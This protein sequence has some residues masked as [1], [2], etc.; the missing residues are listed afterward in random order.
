MVFKQSSLLCI[1]V[2]TKQS[3]QLW[4]RLRNAKML[5]KATRL[6][7]RV[8]GQSRDCLLKCNTARSGTALVRPSITFNNSSRIRKRGRVGA[9][10]CAMFRKRASEALGQ[11][12]LPAA[13]SKTSPHF[14]CAFQRLAE[15]GHAPAIGALSAADGHFLNLR[16]SQLSAANL[17]ILNPKPSD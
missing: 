11:R 12:T 8:A 5:S 9:A 7:G 2:F 17:L 1:N 10:L 13:K 6:Q 4:C 16:T 15:A 14:A 3:C